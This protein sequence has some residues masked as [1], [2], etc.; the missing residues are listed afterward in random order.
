MWWRWGVPEPEDGG[1]TASMPGGEAGLA[2]SGCV[3]LRI[4]ASS[5]NPDLLKQRSAKRLRHGSKRFVQAVSQV[6]L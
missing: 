2:N 5:L 1:R 4:S 6:G 3:R